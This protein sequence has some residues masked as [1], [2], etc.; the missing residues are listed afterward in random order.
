MGTAVTTTLLL[1]LLTVALVGL[2][3]LLGGRGGTVLAFGLA[4]VMNR[5]LL[6]LGPDRAAAP[7]PARRNRSPVITKE[8]MVR[9]R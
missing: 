7:L 3:G 2:G 8:M 4:V 6:V 5:Q 9:C 1:A